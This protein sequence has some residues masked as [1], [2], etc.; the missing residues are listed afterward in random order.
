MYADLK[1]S[2]IN[3]KQIC[4]NIMNLYVYLQSDKSNNIKKPIFLL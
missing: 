2:I 3:D 4:E 1:F